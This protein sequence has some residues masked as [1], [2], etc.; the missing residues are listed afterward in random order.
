MSVAVAVAV[1]LVPVVIVVVA[2]GVAAGTHA[3]VD[4]CVGVGVGE[5]FMRRQPES[6][7]V[8]AMV[9]LELAVLKVLVDLLTGRSRL[10]LQGVMI[11][12]FIARCQCPPTM[13]S[14]EL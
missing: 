14:G 8:D 1:A 11:K 10:G 9:Q 3:C 6:A 13:E 2:V 5:V 12:I 7:F 4:A